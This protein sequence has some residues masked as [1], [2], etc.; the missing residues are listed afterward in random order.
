[1]NGGIFREAHAQAETLVR[2]VLVA[3]FN[4][5]RLASFSEQGVQIIEWVATI[6][7]ATT[8]EC[9]E[10]DG[11][12]W[13]MPDD[14]EDYENY[15]P[16]DHEIPFP[17]PVAHWNCRSVHVPVASVSLSGGRQPKLP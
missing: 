14:P 8:D 12:Q 17:G 11:K 1:M 7:D 3:E 16:I 13:L 10:L 6:D 15:I 5:A 4:T 9:L 2:T